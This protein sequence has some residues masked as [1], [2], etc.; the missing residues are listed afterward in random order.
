MK[1]SAASGISMKTG[2]LLNRSVAGRGQCGCFGAKDRANSRP[3]VTLVFARRM[4]SQGL[5]HILL[6]HTEPFAVALNAVI[7]L[8]HD[9]NFVAKTADAGIRHDQTGGCCQLQTEMLVLRMAVPLAGGGAGYGLSACG[10]KECP[11][12]TLKQKGRL[13]LGAGQTELARIRRGAPCGVIGP[14]RAQALGDIVFL[15]PGDFAGSGF[16]AQRFQPVGADKLDGARAV[17]AYVRPWNG[18]ARP[19]RA[20]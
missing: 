14:Q 3:A 5:A 10:R 13:G 15:E 12:A 8:D 19:T 4:E 2:Y 17:F 1:N 7:A 20:A 18:R 9:R 11:P 6:M 16:G